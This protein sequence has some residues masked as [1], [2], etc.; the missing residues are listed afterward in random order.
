MEI[1]NDQ[2][3][4]FFLKSHERRDRMEMGTVGKWQRTQR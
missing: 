1:M 3:C 4:P 2:V